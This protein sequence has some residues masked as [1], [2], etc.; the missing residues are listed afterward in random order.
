ME[1]VGRCCWPWYQ[2]EQRPWCVGAQGEGVLPSEPM[3]VRLN[4]DGL[5][6]IEISNK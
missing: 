1:A 6:T 4:Q 5:A 2:T 3:G